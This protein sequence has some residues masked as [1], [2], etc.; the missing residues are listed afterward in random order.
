MAHKIV[1]GHV[2]GVKLKVRKTFLVF[3]VRSEAVSVVRSGVLSH[4]MYSSIIF[5]T[6]PQ[7][8][9]FLFTYSN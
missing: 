4:R 5:G 3:P 6:P 2:L 9:H 7:N 1:P 8:C